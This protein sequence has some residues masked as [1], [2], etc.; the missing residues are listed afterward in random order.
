M[1]GTT[2]RLPPVSD[3]SFA[4][5]VLRAERPVLVKFWA[6][7]CGSCRLF[8]PAVRRTAA[9]LG[10]RLH[11]VAMDTEGNA[12]T[13]ARYGVKSLPTLLLFRGGEIVL[14]L[15]GPRSVETLKREIGQVLD[16]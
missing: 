1:A 10:D 7:W 13:V 9:E 12:G 14:R 6:P 11:V 3:D 15:S 4:D 5:A 8:D 16:T 2:D